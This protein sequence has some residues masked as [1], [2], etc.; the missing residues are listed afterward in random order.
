MTV[1][2]LRSLVA[3]N[4]WATVRLLQAAAALSIEE[5]E[6]DLRAISAH[7]RAP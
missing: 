6:R 4:R 2:Q 1:D 7:S 5:L 3:Y